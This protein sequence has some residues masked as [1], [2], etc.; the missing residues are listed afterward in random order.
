[1]TKR[2]LIERGRRSAR[3]LS[4][5]FCAMAL[6][7]L[8][9]VSSTLP[10]FL[11]EDGWEEITFDN[12]TPNRYFACGDDCIGIET[13]A[14][15][16]MIG[17][18]V[19]FAPGATPV[20]EWEWRIESPVVESDLTTKGADDRA[21]AVYVAFAYD[22][23][24]ATF[25]EKLFRPVVELL[26]GDDAPGRGISYVWA[27]FGEP[28]DEFPSPYQSDSSAIIVGRNAA[29]PVG[30]WLSEMFDV[31][32]DYERI[33]GNPAPLVTHVLLSADSDDTDGANR[34]LVRNLRF[35]EG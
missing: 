23:E 28:G 18:P 1:M 30:E 26:R 22:P 25:A 5:F 19:Q 17:R 21:V 7:A 9:A 31:A 2:T 4:V 20:I 6:P 16:S 3:V 10:G 15:V 13:H 32:A 24:S 27:G 29:A 33:F 34:A 14:S 12:K 8:A 11:V 35:K